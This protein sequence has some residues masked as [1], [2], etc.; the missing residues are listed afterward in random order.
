MLSIKEAR[1]RAGLSVNE[2][3][4]KYGM[5]PSIIYKWDNN[6]PRQPPIWTQRMLVIDLLKQRTII[7]DYTDV[8]IKFARDYDNRTIDDSALALV[9]DKDYKIY[10]TNPDL[11]LNVAWA[12][13][14]T[15]EEIIAQAP[16]QFLSTF[17]VKLASSKDPSTKKLLKNIL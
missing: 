16:A 15:N 4:E 12:Y 10:Y 2:M 5:S 9:Y 17:F 11:R 14:L 7:D 8:A 1:Q 6:D 13:K 3:S